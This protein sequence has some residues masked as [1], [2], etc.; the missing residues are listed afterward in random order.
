MR[1]SKGYYDRIFAEMREQ[2]WQLQKNSPGDGYTRYQFFGHPTAGGTQFCRGLREAQIFIEG[3]LKG[4]ESL[5]Y[6]KKKVD[7]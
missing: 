1:E 6:V 4:V 5:Q 2:G 7:P 3:F